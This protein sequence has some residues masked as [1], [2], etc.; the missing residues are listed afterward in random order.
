MF[1]KSVFQTVRDEQQFRSAE[2]PSLF[3]PE[4]QFSDLVTAVVL[5]TFLLLFRITLQYSLFNYIFTRFP[6]KIRSKLSENLFYSMY[7]SAAFFYYF[8]LLRPKLEWST[9][10]LS[11]A[12]NVAKDI[13]Y[14]VPA[15]MIQG[16]HDYY[17]QS[18]AFYASALLFLVVFDSR[19]SDF[20][21]LVLHHVVT[22]GLVVMS[23][24]YSYV[25]AGIVIMALHDVGDIFLYTAKFVHHLGIRGLDTAIFTVFAVTFYVTRLVMFSRTCHAI[26]I[27]SLQTAVAERGFNR[28]LMFYDTYLLHWLFFTVFLCTLLT[29][30]CFWFA[31]I[32]KM[33]YREAF[34]GKKIS[35]EGDIRSDDEDEDD[36]DGKDVYDDQIIKSTA[37]VKHL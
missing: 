30:H 2:Q 23:Y 28:W 27:E 36:A 16:E 33:I 8:F 11:N 20:R 26:I 22:I 15:P 34:L 19:R 32:L 18:A 1:V 5:A 7:Y 12:T 31:L 3:N 37:H 10:L 21:E 9:N 35:E 25:R 24:L 29:L 6:K 13:V 4:I 17:A 14:P